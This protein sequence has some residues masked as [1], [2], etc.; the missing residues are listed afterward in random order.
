MSKSEYA[1]PPNR[2][3]GLVGLTGQNA[4]Y[5]VSGRA[6]YAFRWPLS[7][8]FVMRFM[9]VDRFDSRQVYLHD[10]GMAGA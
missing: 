8:R 9:V 10:D 3:T 4:G 5:G 6:S 2:T 7:V 1:P